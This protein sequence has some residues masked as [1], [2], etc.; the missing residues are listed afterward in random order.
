[1]TLIEKGKGHSAIEVF[2]VDNDIV[3]SVS[4]RKVKF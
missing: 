3:L 2:I 1:M 4:P